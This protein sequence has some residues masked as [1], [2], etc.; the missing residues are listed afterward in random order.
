VERVE[1]DFEISKMSVKAPPGADAEMK[2]TFEE[3]GRRFFHTN[4]A[5]LYTGLLLARRDVEAGKL[6]AAAF[7]LDDSPALK[8]A[9]VRTALAHGVRAAEF[10]EWVEGAEK[11]EVEG[12][13]ELKKRLEGEK[14]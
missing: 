13:G 4:T 8:V 2:R 7:R 14:R 9:M 3:S 10:G 11:A 1:R 12:V 5:N 6:A